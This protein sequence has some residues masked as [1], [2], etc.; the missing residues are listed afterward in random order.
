M[1]T[2]NLLPVGTVVTVK[3]ANKSMMIIGILP[4]NNEKRYDYLSVLYPEG[5]L[6][7]EQMY[8]FNQE[9][10]DKV[11]YLGYMNVEYQEFRNNLTLAMTEVEGAR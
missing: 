10:V 7:P 6:T 11:Q 1:N 5:Y 3:G 2:A 8:L 4:E 9:D